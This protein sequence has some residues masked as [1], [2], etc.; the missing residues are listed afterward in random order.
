MGTLG[1]LAL[2]KLGL[3]SFVLASQDVSSFLSWYKTRQEQVWAQTLQT[4]LQP[5]EQGKPT[6]DAQKDAAVKGVADAWANM[7]S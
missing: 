5:L 2:I 7:P 4:A 6:T 3:Q 1:I